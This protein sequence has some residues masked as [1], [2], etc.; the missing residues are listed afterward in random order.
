MALMSG[1]YCALLRNLCELAVIEQNR[2]P[3]QTQLSPGHYS[4]DNTPRSGSD[5]DTDTDTEKIFT[6]RLFGCATCTKA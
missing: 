2:T 6:L 1:L 3:A 5:T 4:P